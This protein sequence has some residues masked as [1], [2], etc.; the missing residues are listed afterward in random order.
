[1]S[2]P[3]TTTAGAAAYGSRMTIE[4]KLDA[5]GIVAG[6]MARSLSFYR[7]LGLPV[8]DGAEG[9]PH[10]EVPLGGGMRLMFDT[11][12]TVRS[13]HPDWKAVPG[14]G[15]IGLAASLPD[16]AAV[17]AVYAELT[18][19][20][21]RGELEPFDAPWGQRYASMQDPDGNSVDLY[22]PLAS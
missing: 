22:A 18:A 9:Q 12:E 11:E 19:A 21:H 7:A 1:M 8:P 20:G 5:I 4:A 3:F 6:D 15:R 14:A 2:D 10:V 13:F 16:A 17:D